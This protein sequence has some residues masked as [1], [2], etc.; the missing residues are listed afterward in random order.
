MSQRRIA[1]NNS[2]RGRAV[3]KRRANSNGVLYAIQ[4]AGAPLAGT[5]TKLLTSVI[6]D[7]APA[8]V[9]RSDTDAAIKASSSS[10]GR[11]RCDSRGN[12]AAQRRRASECRS[13]A[14][15]SDLGATPLSSMSDQD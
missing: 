3:Q 9:R 2:A 10:H 15:H 6:A 1:S 8:A 4:L 7:V 11:R 14:I 13:V 5:C 12:A